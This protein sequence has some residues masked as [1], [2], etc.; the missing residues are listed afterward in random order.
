[1]G[2]IIKNRCKNNYPLEGGIYKKKKK[3]KTVITS[4]WKKMNDLSRKGT[5]FEFFNINLKLLYSTTINDN[6]IHRVIS[7]YEKQKIWNKS[8]H[9]KLVINLKIKYS[10]I[11]M[12]LFN[13]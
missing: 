10:R 3:K 1:M 4:F 9:F 11:K 7:I 6:I 5:N 13:I 12:I 2:A 8:H